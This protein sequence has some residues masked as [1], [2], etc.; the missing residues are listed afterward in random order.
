MMTRVGAAAATIAATA[1]AGIA[2][3]KGATVSVQPTVWHVLGYAFEAGPMIAGLVACF[4]VRFYII[5][6]DYPTHRWSLDIPISALALM[7][8]AATV[9]RLRPDPIMALFYGTTWGVVGA[10]I[11][12]LA[13][14]HSDRLMALLG[15]GE[16]K[17]GA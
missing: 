3:D 8:A 11:I 9:I 15:L 10:G 14:K 1:A 17:P 6:K 12:A 16:T 2:S 5:R 4:A 7:F 13:K